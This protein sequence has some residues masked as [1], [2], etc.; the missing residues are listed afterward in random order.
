MS[1]DR[2]PPGQLTPKDKKPKRG[3]TKKYVDLEMVERLASIQCT[4]SEIAS[5]LGLSVDTVA[6]NLYFAEVYK[7]GAE[8]G[9]TSLRRMPFESANKGNVVMQIWLEKQYLGQSDRATTEVY[10]LPSLANISS[11][12]LRE[13]LDEY[14]R[15]F[16][17]V[18]AKSD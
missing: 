9:R 1:A 12:Q 4:H 8:G 3:R 13:L 5:A 7:R 2:I 14:T 6:R 10:S 18:A 11:L 17:D 16:P 15:K